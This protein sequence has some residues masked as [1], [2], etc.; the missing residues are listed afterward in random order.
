MKAPPNKHASAIMGGIA[1]GAAI[2]ATFSNRIWEGLN[3][4]DNQ[5]KARGAIAYKK[6]QIANRM[7]QWIPGVGQE[8]AK[9]QYP[10][11]HEKEET[12]GSSNNTG[13]TPP[14][15]PRAGQRP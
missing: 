2:P 8:W 1:G 11:L 12:S 15:T 14:Q 4:V 7:I 9:R 13:N 3:K 10:W 6:Q 5:G